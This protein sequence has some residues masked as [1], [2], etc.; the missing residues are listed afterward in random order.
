MFLRLFPLALATFAVGTDGFVIAGLLPAIAADL[1]VG[2]AAAGQ[3][4]T[5]FALTFA[6][7]APVLG[8]ATAALDRRKAL[9]AALTVFV[10]GN[11][12]TALAP[13]Y[14]I[15]LTSRILTAAGAGIITSTASSAGAAMVPPER[16]GRALATVMG[17]LVSASALGLPIGTLIGG[18]DWRITMWV[19]A[20]V[21]VVAA[22]GIAV[23][24]PALSLPVPSLRDRVAYLVRP[25]VLVTL[26][27]TVAAMAGTYILYT[28]IGVALEG[29]TGG[30]AALLT[31]VLLLW[32]LGAVAGNTLVGRLTDRFDATTVLAWSIAAAVVLLAVSPLVVASLPAALA[33]GALWGVATGFPTVAQQH[34]L[35]TR[36]PEATPILL[37]LNSSAVYAGIALG[38][39]LGGIAQTWLTPA[40]LGL[41]GAAVMVVALGF[42]LAG[43]R[44]SGAAPVA[45]A[46]Q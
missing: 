25:W 11:V 38:G 2:V 21:G 42:V 26:A 41:P 20:G 1:D 3:L 22:I 13:T 18:A 45:S 14:E 32:G 15:A 6:A 10:I 16:R 39:A 43:S 37:G 7:A 40:Q 8:A 27:P 35:V 24:L 44:L 30:S 19:V 9:L 28:Y 5:A 46:Q 12:A 36:A 4:V 29:A 17:G 23:R 33:W 34:R 31:I